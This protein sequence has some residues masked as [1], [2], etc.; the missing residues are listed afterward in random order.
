VVAEWFISS[1]DDYKTLTQYE[2]FFSEPIL[3]RK[4]NEPRWPV[5]VLI[6][7]VP[8]QADYRLFYRTCQLTAAEWSVC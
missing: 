8:S 6:Q 3:S 7:A 4:S 5:W 2:F 1:T